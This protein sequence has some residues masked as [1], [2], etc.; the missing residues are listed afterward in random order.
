MKSAH[1]IFSLTFYIVANC[2]QKKNVW[3]FWVKL[4][5][6]VAILGMNS[7][8]KRRLDERERGRCGVGIGIGPK[9]P[10]S[11]CDNPSSFSGMPRSEE[12][13]P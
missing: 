10:S 1:A 13:I 9:K 6:I 12:M 4:E 8:K 11:K 7:S 5:N 2:Y 3:R